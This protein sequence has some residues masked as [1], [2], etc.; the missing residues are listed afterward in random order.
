MNKTYTLSMTALVVALLATA[1]CNQQPREYDWNSG[2][3][4]LRKNALKLFAGQNVTDSLSDPEGDHTDWKEIRVREP[5]TMGLTVAVDDPRGMKGFISIKD[6]FGVELDRRPM[7]GS[8]SLYVFDRIPVYQ[9]EYYVQIFMDRGKSVYTA[10]VTFEPLPQGTI[11]DANPNNNTGANGGNGGITTRPNP[12]TGP[13]RKPPGETG[14]GE[15]GDGENPPEVVDP[16]EDESVVLRGRIARIIPMDD[17]GSQL[18]I[19]GF[20]AND[21]VATGMSGTIVGLGQGFRITRVLPTSAVAFTKAEAADLAP[22]KNVVLKVKK[23]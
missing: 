14:D 18:V 12:G 3:D 9:G 7:S 15:T 5:G 1:A 17:G 2:N 23:R 20:G 8:E 16:P 21:G 19:A 11:P 6:G 13:G 22:Y 4:N 10:G